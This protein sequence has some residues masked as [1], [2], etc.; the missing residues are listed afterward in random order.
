MVKGKAAQKKAFLVKET[1]ILSFYVK[2]IFF[3]V[4]IT[5]LSLFIEFH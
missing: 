3:C 2:K 5:F 1:P 4:K